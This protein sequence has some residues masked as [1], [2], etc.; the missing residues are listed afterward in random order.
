MLLAPVA[1]QMH[2]APLLSWLPTGPRTF[3]P[4]LTSVPL[5]V[6]PGLCLLRTGLHISPAPYAQEPCQ[7][8]SSAYPSLSWWQSCPHALPTDPCNMVLPASV[9]KLHPVT[10]STLSV[11]QIWNRTGSSNDPCGPSLLPAS[12]QH[13]THYPPGSEACHPTG[14]YLC[15]CL[16]TQA[17]ISQLEYKNIVEIVL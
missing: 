6:L 2:G 9:M 4:A 14:I 1:D 15:G 5:A 7:T 12:R 13:A 16:P 8:V 10:L 11:L 17:V 3:S